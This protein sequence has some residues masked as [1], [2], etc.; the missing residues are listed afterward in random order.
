[1]LSVSESAEALGVSGARVRA[2]IASGALPAVKIGRVWALREEDVFGRAAAKPRG[3]RPREDEGDAPRDAAPSED[4]RRLYR[5]CKRAFRVRPSAADVLA[6]ESGEE[7]AFY[8]AVADFF[9][10]SRQAELV[11]AGVY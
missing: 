9:L 10:K 4:F 7:A 6:A 1:M 5:E 11:K 2:L 3:G 8:M